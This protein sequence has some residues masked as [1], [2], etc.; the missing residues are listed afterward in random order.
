VD[1][2]G[3]G[4]HED[5]TTAIREALTAAHLNEADSRPLM[6]RV[7]LVGETALAGNLEDG[8]AQLRAEVQAL[9][10]AISPDLWLEKVRVDLASPK[11][12]ASSPL[13]EDLASLLADAS[14]DPGLADIL[15][16]ELRAFL[17]GL[18]AREEGDEEGEL[19]AAA[20]RKD[21]SQLLNVA[22]ES[23]PARL[24]GKR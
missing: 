3:A 20:V 14:Q 23:L 12:P 17:T 7:V 16:D 19:T 24:T 22:A 4:R 8:A 21:W 5:V 9:G 15:S 18:P 11:L 2:T 1:C 6:V 10:M 13:P